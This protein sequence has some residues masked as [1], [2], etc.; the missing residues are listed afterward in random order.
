MA[1]L[2]FEILID[3]AFI[4]ITTSAQLTSLVSKR[5]L[6]LINDF[7]DAEWRY[8]KFQ[9]YLWDNIAETALSQRERSALVNQSHSSLIAAARNLRLTDKD[10]VGEGSEIAEVFLYGLM[11]HHF[12][13]LSVVPKIFYKQNIQDNAKGA[14]SVHI[15]VNGDDFTLWFGEA[16]FYNSIADARLDSVVTSVL[17]SLSTDKLKKENAIITSLSDLDELPISADL[18]GRIKSAL[19]NRESIDNLKSRIH[20]PILL[21]HECGTT[22]GATELSKGYKAEIAAFHKGRAESYFSK[23]LAKAGSIHKYDD[24]NFHIILFPVPSKKTVVDGFVQTVAF[25]KGH[26]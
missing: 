2:T 7:E 22:A 13:A 26:K 20:I 24:L 5:V 3:D 25:Y 9:N 12:G 19:D 18:R 16:K 17:N 1:G 14:D 21:L 11:R 15:V 23:Q 6:S 8:S 4:G 10:K